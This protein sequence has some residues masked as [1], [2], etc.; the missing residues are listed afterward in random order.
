MGRAMELLRLGGL[1][2]V[3]SGAWFHAPLLI[4]AGFTTIYWHVIWG[5]S[6]LRWLF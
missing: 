4:G 1:A 2:G 5:Y 6:R 3:W